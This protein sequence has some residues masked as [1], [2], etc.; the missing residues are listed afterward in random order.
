MSSKHQPQGR[1]LADLTESVIG[2]LKWLRDTDLT[3]ADQAVL[4]ELSNRLRRLLI[5][6]TLHR[7]R[8][9]LGLK[10]EPR[11]TTIEA[12][13]MSGENVIFSQT[14]GMERD[15]TRVAHVSLVQGAWTPAEVKARY[16]AQKD[17]PKEIQ[18]PLS[19]WL[20]A[21]CMKADGV[22]V[23]RRVVIQFVAN[24]LGGVHYDPQRN[25]T[26]DVAYIALDQAREG[27]TIL[28]LDAVYG[29]LAAIGQELWA[30]PDIQ[31]LLP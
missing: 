29:Q 27:G 17:G 11:I 13:D 30:S 5:E 18:R 31:A 20:S 4:R 19:K 22:V 28:G 26:K 9:A 8:K 12:P 14:G 25:P 15:G 3:T 21:G 7:L 6:G 10:G 1:D 24:K 2:D 23:Q 16:E